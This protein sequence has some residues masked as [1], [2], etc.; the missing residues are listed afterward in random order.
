MSTFICLMSGEIVL[1]SET[2]RKDNGILVKLQVP[3][4][5]NKVYF[6]DFDILSIIQIFPQEQK[7]EVFKMLDWKKGMASVKGDY[8]EV[9]IADS[10]FSDKRVVILSKEEDNYIMLTTWRDYVDVNVMEYV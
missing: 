9:W 7:E 2:E 4:K 1:A 6:S 3:P 5:E 10:I 8:K